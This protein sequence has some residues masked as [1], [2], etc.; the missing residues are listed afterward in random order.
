MSTRSV[1]ASAALLSLLLGAGVA[2]PGN[3]AERGGGGVR[4]VGGC[5]GGGARWTLKAKHDDGR[6][7]VEGE[8]DSHRSGQVWHW[9]F[10]HNA[11]I[12]AT[13]RSTTAGLSSSF[14]VRRRMAD[15]AGADHVVFRATH[16]QQVC[17]G[18]VAV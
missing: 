17:R 11:S 9:T 13:G 12:S 6:I 3:A 15:L 7:E 4:A 2:A 18:T 8:I 10:D 1:L 14:E 16:G 5:S